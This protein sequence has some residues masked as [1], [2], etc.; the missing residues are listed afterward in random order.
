MCCCTVVD[1]LKLEALT[2]AV[3]TFAPI[4]KGDPGRNEIKCKM[5]PPC[6]KR[7]PFKIRLQLQ[8]TRWNKT[9]SFTLHSV[10]TCRISLLKKHISHKT[11]R[12][13]FNQLKCE[14]VLP[15]TRET[16]QNTP[17]IEVK[18]L[19]QHHETE[20]DLCHYVTLLLSRKIYVL[21]IFTL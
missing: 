19:R 18:N 5:L 12:N 11:L 14:G 9:L 20:G 16:A 21:C 10:L 6:K 13:I 17:S 8:V 1:L 7:S 4:W 3:C 15:V 2:F